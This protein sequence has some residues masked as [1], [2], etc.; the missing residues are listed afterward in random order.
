MQ[1]APN[2][3]SALPNDTTPPNYVAFRSKRVRENELS[4]E[5]NDFK[6][7]IKL[8]ISSLISKQTSELQKIVKTQ[9]DIQQI[10]VNIEN[11]IAFLTSQNEEFKKKINQLDGKIKEDRQYITVLEDRIEDLQRSNRKNNFEIK[12]V[13]S[14]PNETKEQLVD[15]VICLSQNIGYK[16]E[17][18]NI[19]DIYRV[20]GKGEKVKST[21]IV[22]ETSSTLLKTGFLKMCKSF[23]IKNKTKLRAKHLGFCKDEET[24]IYV[25]EQLTAK[26]SRLY[27]LA[28]DLAKSK[29]YRFCWTAYGKIYVRKDENS[30]II[31]ITS[32]A[33]VQHLLQM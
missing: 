11:S 25:S 16:I 5:F 33:Q 14:K 20:R 28:R 13:P 19:T 18:S 26:G 23:N 31:H 12:N 2:V 9:K 17:K 4:A 29:T 32:V 30:P 1:N 6:E 24:P 3:S 27:F 10:N 21:P 22:V 15:M 8:M 7:E